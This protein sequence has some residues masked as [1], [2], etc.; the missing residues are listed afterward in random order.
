M[1]TALDGQV[2]VNGLLMGPGTPYVVTA[3]NPYMKVA[4]FTK[5]PRA[6][7]SGSWSGREDN[8]T[9]AIPL[10][11]HID[12]DDD[13][14]WLGAQQTLAAA[15]Q[16]SSSDVELRWRINGIE[17]LMFVRPRLVEPATEWMAHGH[18]PVTC[19][20]EALDPSV[21][22]A[23]EN[24]TVLTLPSASGGLTFP[25]TAP[26]TIDATVTSGRTTIT[27]AG[28]TT[29]GLL[30]RIDAFGASLQEP[31]VSVLT[32]GVPT[33][34]RAEFTLTAGQWL[35]IDTARR[36]AYLNGTSSRR[37][38]MSGD[39]PLLPKGTSDIA[40]DAGLYSAAAQLTVTW[41]DT[42]A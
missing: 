9:V 4:R 35:E 5:T 21:Y 37:G 11:L 16:A 7:G 31:R 38:Y 40:F 41:R 20:L 2:E 39:F 12:M 19:A 42:Y 36:T 32:N 28:T 22:G 23:A 14:G 26:F 6:W 30:L 10:R 1:A 17:Y 25:M 34:L 13:A 27:N 24:T 29:T 18:G 15:L 8:D 3:F 33:V